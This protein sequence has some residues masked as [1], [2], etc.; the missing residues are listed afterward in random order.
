MPLDIVC[1]DWHHAVHVHNC[2][3]SLFG[4]FLNDRPICDWEHISKLNYHKII[5]ESGQIE[6]KELI[7]ILSMCFIVFAI[8]QEH[9]AILL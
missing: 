2:L 7:T 3:Q 6:Q 9:F 4:G 5:L 1:R 8:V